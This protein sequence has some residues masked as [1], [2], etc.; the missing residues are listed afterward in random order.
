MYRSRIAD[1]S[2]LQIF[3]FSF[4][5]FASYLR[6][7]REFQSSISCFKA[8]N[9]FNSPLL[10]P[11]LALPAEEDDKVDHDAFGL[12]EPPGLRQVQN[13]CNHHMLHGSGLWI[14][15]KQMG[16]LIV[17]MARQ[18]VWMQ[19][20]VCFWAREALSRNTSRSSFTSS[21]LNRHYTTTVMTWWSHVMARIARTPNSK[22][23]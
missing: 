18:V 1:V 22:N 4:A 21:P 3:F 7:Q 11:Q 23:R 12:L 13:I 9:I 17:T 15:G 8:K 14:C 20:R 10:K 6:Q 5:S 19:V 16:C 2:S